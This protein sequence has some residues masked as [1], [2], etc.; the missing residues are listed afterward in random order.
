M[1]LLKKYLLL[2]ILLVSQYGMAQICVNT[3]SNYKMFGSA[4]RVGTLANGHELAFQKNTFSDHQEFSSETGADFAKKIQQM[5]SGSCSII[6]GLFTSRE[7]LISGPLLK[8]NKIIGI[9]STC[10]HDNISLFSP[11]L[12]TIIPA[13]SVFSNKTSTYL[14]EHPS[15]EKLFVIYQPTDVYSKTSHEVFKKGIKKPIIEIPVTS[16]GH[17]D[18][19]K[20]SISSNERFTIVFFTYAL[21]SAK[22]LMQLSAHQIITK[23]TT[24]IGASCW[25]FDVTVFRPLRSILEKAKKVLATD[26][27]DW[28]TVK[29]TEFVKKFTTR[30]NRKPLTIEILTYDVTQL[31]ISCYKKSLVNNQYDRNRFQNCMINTQHQGVSG[32]F[33]FSK[34]SPFAE[35]R[36][37]LTN[38]FDR[39]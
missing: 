38:F 21:P 13:I 4:P 3:S 9:S 1:H 23:K 33:S 15:S 24:I 27:L 12:Y 39:M 34:D 25:T 11:Y 30:F 35:R 26:V 29:E 16:N 18:I 32:R 31:A 20:F 37:Y 14:N 8:R 6:L 5:S 10:G 7:C 36:L 22:I 19:N 2:S 17:F 28:N